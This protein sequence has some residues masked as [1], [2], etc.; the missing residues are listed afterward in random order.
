MPE[1]TKSSL[2]KMYAWLY[3]VREEEIVNEFELV[4]FNRV[5]KLSK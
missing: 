4:D 5:G 2:R 1:Q 3:A